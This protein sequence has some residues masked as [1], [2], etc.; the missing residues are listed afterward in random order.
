M[1][2]P[3]TAPRWKTKICIRHFGKSCTRCCTQSWPLREFILSLFWEQIRMKNGLFSIF[4]PR[5][6]INDMFSYFSTSHLVIEDSPSRQSSCLPKSSMDSAFQFCFCCWSASPPHSQ[7][8]VSK[9]CRPG[10]F[11]HFCIL[12]F[13]SFLPTVAYTVNK[14]G[15]QCIKQR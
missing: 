10:I 9:F 6:M 14:W 4:C 8:D 5:K 2:K 3:V 11:V 7:L 1:M 15:K 12:H 13:A